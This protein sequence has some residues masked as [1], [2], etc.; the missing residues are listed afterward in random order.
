MKSYSFS[1]RT[2]ARIEFVD[3]TENVVEF[4]KNSE[5]QN[6]YIKI[7][8]THTTAGI[9]INQNADINVQKD[10][11]NI[12]N[13]FI[14]K[15]DFLNVEGN[16]D[17]HFNQSLFGNSTDV[18]I[19]EGKLQLGE[20]QAVFL[21]EFDGPRTRKVLIQIYGDKKNE[22]SGRKLNSLKDIIH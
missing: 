15:T 20:W 8:S 22:N 12:L 19:S 1:I 2:S 11:V 14:P 6:G 18:F 4:T 16:S 9:T 21:C 3:I 7:L 13:K 10:M 17:A 5:I